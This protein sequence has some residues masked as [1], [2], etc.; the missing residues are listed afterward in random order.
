M[1]ERNRNNEQQFIEFFVKEYNE[2]NRR[3]REEEENYDFIMSHM[4]PTY[5]E[6]DTYIQ[7]YVKNLKDEELI[8]RADGLIKAQNLKKNDYLIDHMTDKGNGNFSHF[9]AQWSPI[10]W[11]ANEKPD[12]T[13]IKIGEKIVNAS[14]LNF[15]IAEALNK[16]SKTSYDLNFSMAQSIDEQD[17]SINSVNEYHLWVKMQDKGQKDIETNGAEQH[18]IDFRNDFIKLMDTRETEIKRVA[19]L[20]ASCALNPNSA[21]QEIAQEKLKFILFKLSELRRLRDKMQATQSVADRKKENENKKEIYDDR[22]T[23]V[24]SQRDTSIDTQNTDYS[25]AERRLNNL[26]IA[27]TINHHLINNYSRT[28]PETSSAEEATNKINTLK[29]NLDMFK[30]MRNGMTKEEWEKS[31]EED[32]DYTIPQPTIRRRLGFDLARYQEALRDLTA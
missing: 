3:I 5:A 11:Q 16:K 8:A 13:K 30:A 4:P 22:I 29:L 10:I 14:D 18:E 24:N 15:S 9:R 7:N 25:L 2:M 17:C 1:E 21:L 27:H 6:T 28:K 20:Y 32:Q 26:F 19:Q 23:P 31:L 12:T